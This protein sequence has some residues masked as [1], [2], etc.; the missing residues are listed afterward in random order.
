M[1]YLMVMHEFEGM[2]H[3]FGNNFN[4]SLTPGDFN[5]VPKVAI[6]HVLHNDVN[7][8]IFHIASIKCH[9]KLIPGLS[10]FWTATPILISERKYEL[11]SSS[12]L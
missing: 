5:I 6:W 12:R 7:D 4:I 8:I 10:V 11:N 1:N 9:N 2:K 3:L